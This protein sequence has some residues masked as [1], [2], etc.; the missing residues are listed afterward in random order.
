MIMLTRSS[1]RICNSMCYTGCFFLLCSFVSRR[2]FVFY[3][4]ILVVFMIMLARSSQR[5]HNPMRYTGCIHVYVRSFFGADLLVP[6]QFRGFASFPGIKFPP[7][8]SAG[9][10]KSRVFITGDSPTNGQLFGISE[11]ISYFL[12]AIYQYSVLN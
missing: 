2:G 10:H 11:G 9:K 5:I 6:V 3:C 8:F 7:K 12:Y 1:E 4:A